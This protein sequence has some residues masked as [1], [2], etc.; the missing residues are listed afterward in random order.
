LLLLGG[1][2][3]LRLVVQSRLKREKKLL[4]QARR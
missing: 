3:L 2:V 1:M 4:R